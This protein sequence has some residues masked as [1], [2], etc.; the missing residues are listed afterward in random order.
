M[1]AVTLIL[2]FVCV[3]VAGLLLAHVAE[4]EQEIAI[5]LA[6]GASRVMCCG[7]GSSRVFPII[8][9][10]SA[11]GEVGGLT[12]AQIIERPAPRSEVIAGK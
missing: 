11:G 4:R 2:V 5:R 9:F 12:G 8:L 1:G 3:N 7:N 10:H 6:V